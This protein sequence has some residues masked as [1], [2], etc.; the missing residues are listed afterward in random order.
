[1]RSS[2]LGSLYMERLETEIG[3]T[4]DDFF[5]NNRQSLSYVITTTALTKGGLNYERTNVILNV[6]Y[7]HPA[8]WNLFFREFKNE[9]RGHQ[10]R[11]LNRWDS[12][13]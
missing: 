12:E 10:S 6:H 13:L 11:L 3:G 4:Y 9:I 7:R 2:E 5:C 8:S 1:M